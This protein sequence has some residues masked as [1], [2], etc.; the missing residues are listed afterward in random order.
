MGAEEQ[1]K[2]L[3]ILFTRELKESDSESCLA[4]KPYRPYCLNTFCFPVKFHL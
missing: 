3:I 4:A 2:R 1:A